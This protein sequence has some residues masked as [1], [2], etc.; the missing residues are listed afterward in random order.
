MIAIPPPSFTVFTTNTVCGVNHQTWLTWL[1]IGSLTFW[2]NKAYG[3]F[4]SSF[5]VISM[6][7]DL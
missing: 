3:E 7:V 4:A 5:Y 2:A 6:M 1:L